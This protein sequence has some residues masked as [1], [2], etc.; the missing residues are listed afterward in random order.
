MKTPQA[1][2]Q[3]NIAIPCALHELIRNHCRARGLVIKVFV[4][5]VLEKKMRVGAK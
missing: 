4:R 3:V 1:N 2:D 5:D